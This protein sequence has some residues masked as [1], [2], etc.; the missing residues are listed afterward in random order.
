MSKT[1]ETKALTKTGSTAITLP[2]F[3]KVGDSRGSENVATEDLK[4][5]RVLLAQGLSPELV[6]GDP[7]YIPG[8]KLGDAFNSVT[9]E[10]YGKGPI[11]VV[12]VRAEPVK[13]IEFYPRNSAEGKGVKD[14]DVKPDDPR[15]RWQDD[16]KPPVATKFLEFVALL[17]ADLEPVILTFKGTGL[18]TARDLSTF[19]KLPVKGHGNVPA[20]ARRFSLTASV[21]RD[22]DKTYAVFTARP[23]GFVDEAT[24]AKASA[25]FESIKK[26]KVAD[27]EAAAAAGAVPD[28]VPF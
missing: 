3:I 7:A 22:G 26:R 5:P 24:Y 16:G 6:E 19:I 1:E 17:G 25:F 13:Y 10:V 27:D 2:D 4:I 23:T 11:E 9:R 18:K 21:V 15:T 14:F 28:D 20:F 12:I 8:I